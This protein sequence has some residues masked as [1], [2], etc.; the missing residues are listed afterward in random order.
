MNLSKVQAMEGHVFHHLVVQTV[1]VRKLMNKQF[2]HVTLAL[3]AV[4]QV[5][6]QN[7]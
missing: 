6:D 1:D 7:A 4:P 5:A 2:A 3:L